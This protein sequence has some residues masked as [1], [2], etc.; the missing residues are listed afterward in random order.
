MSVAVQMV[1]VNAKSSGLS[2]DDWRS[3][4]LS[5]GR[6]GP[7]EI[8]IQGGRKEMLRSVTRTAGITEVVVMPLEKAFCIALVTLAG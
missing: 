2:D 1:V 6:S 5:T 4:L 3:F 8:R 7:W